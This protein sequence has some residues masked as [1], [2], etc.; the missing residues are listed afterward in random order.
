VSNT[1]RNWP[2]NRSAE[3]EAGGRKRRFGFASL[4]LG[5]I[6]GGV[7]LGGSFGLTL[8]VLAYIDT[9]KQ[10]ERE[11]ATAEVRPTTWQTSGE[12]SYEIRNGSVV[13][14]G[15][16]SIYNEV[17]CGSLVSKIRFSLFVEHADQA[18]IELQ[19]I[20]KEMGPIGDPLVQDIG[21]ISNQAVEIR[22]DTRLGA[23]LIRAIIYS[24][25]NKSEVVAFRDPLIE[26]KP[27]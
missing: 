3:R 9:W 12:A 20:S 2:P 26:C 18:N 14:S 19:F 24:P 16:D 1:P 5:T 27:V 10:Q 23:G 15:P 22:A 25:E 8:Y 6:G 4:L 13:F 17:A 7:V 21:G 11:A